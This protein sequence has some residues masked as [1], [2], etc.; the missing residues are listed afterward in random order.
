MEIEMSELEIP[1]SGSG[2]CVR[3]FMLSGELEKHDWEEHGIASEEGRMRFEGLFRE[4]QHGLLRA[5]AEYQDSFIYS[6][7]ERPDNRSGK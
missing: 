5:S 1:Q 3:C 6:G 4:Y 2:V 7:G